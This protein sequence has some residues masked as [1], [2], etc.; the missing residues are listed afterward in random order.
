MAQQGL[1]ACPRCGARPKSATARFCSR[2]GLT[3]PQAQPAPTGGHRA[4]ASGAT[5]TRAAP[6]V[7]APPPGQPVQPQYA[8]A[9]VNPR[10]NPSA[11]VAKSGCGCVLAVLLLL[12]VFVGIFSLSRDEYTETV[13]PA[14]PRETVLI[15][16]PSL[17][18]SRPYD[19]FIVPPLP[20]GVKQYPVM[21]N[22]QIQ[23]NRD[24]SGTEQ[25][26]MQGNIGAGGYPCVLW[27]A[28]FVDARGDTIKARGSLYANSEGAFSA[29][30][31]VYAT[32][33][34]T[35]SS[36]RVE[37]TLP[38]SAAQLSPAAV[39]FC[40]FDENQTELARQS[41]PVPAERQ[42]S[43]DYSGSNQR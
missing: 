27:V 7:I 41:L 43:R 5:P 4:A 17:L 13:S 35:G 12:G 32:M 36:K 33:D 42:R 9:T 16:E 40:L 15:A 39:Q 11:P 24:E 38:T 8:G 28:Y 34:S 26:Q 23:R 31:W 22:L 19:F 21:H 30:A 29:G 2:C 1:A 18:P 37:L 20:V 10:Y 14:L 6:P 25:F 3:L